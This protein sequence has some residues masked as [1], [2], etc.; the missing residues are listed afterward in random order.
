MGRG[1]GVTDRDQEIQQLCCLYINALQSKKQAMYHT[2]SSGMLT[3][4][5]FLTY[6]AN[7]L[8]PRGRRDWGGERASKE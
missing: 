7:V 4:H 5:F 2:L 3:T 6:M 8:L 1:E